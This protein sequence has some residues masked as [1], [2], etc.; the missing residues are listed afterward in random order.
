MPFYLGLKNHAGQYI[1]VARFI[2]CGAMAM[3]QITPWFKTMILNKII[4]PMFVGGYQ[5][6]LHEIFSFRAVK[7]KHK[8]RVRWYFQQMIKLTKIKKN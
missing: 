7:M 2:G 1:L 6:D 3:N 4:N 5:N 8:R